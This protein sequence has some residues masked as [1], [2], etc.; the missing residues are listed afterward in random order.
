MN[1]NIPLLKLA[2]HLFHLLS[3]LVKPNKSTVPSENKWLWIFLLYLNDKEK[4]LYWREEGNF[5]G[6]S[7]SRSCQRQLEPG[8][9]LANQIF[10]LTNILEPGGIPANQIFHLINILEPCR[11]LANQIFY[12]TNILEPVRTLANKIFYLTNI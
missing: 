7:K 11:I 3:R 12:L 2:F 4:V 6:S 8:R 1:L 9:I 10:Y 5:A